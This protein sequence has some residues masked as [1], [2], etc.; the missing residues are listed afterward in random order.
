MIKKHKTIL[1][2]LLCLFA[3]ACVGASLTVSSKKMQ[4]SN[5]ERIDELSRQISEIK[6]WKSE[7]QQNGESETILEIDLEELLK[8]IENKKTSEKNGKQAEGA[9]EKLISFLKEKEGFSSKRYFCS[10]GKE[11]IGYGFTD[12]GIKT[13]IRFG[14]LPKD[15]KLPRAMSK[16]EADKFLRDIIVPTFE[17]M[18]SAK[19]KVN[20][21]EHQKMALVSFAYNLGESNLNNIIKDVNNKKDPT[22]RIKLYVNAKGRPLK[23]L[24]VR[25]E[26]EIAMW[27]GDL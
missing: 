24:R 21:E 3:I 20:L 26:H 8:I 12:A 2:T 25:R 27:K 17:R 14:F 16:D 5:I 1:S 15:Y 10:G 19:V 9:K 23:G 11:T 4:A 22:K 13:A 18:V 7:V 6:K